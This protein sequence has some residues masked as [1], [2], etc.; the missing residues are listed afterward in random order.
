MVI[1]RP[2]TMAHD[3]VAAAKLII[4]EIEEAIALKEKE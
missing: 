2:I 4:T 3:P 1:G